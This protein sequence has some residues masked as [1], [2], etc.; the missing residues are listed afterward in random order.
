MIE[1]GLADMSR[2]L[3]EKLEEML[4]D[5]A[6]AQ[7]GKDIYLSDLAIVMLHPMQSAH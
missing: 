5:V 1:K 2:V 7:N 3:I 4:V 6:D